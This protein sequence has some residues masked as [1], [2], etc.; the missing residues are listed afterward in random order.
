MLGEPPAN[1]LTSHSPRALGGRRDDWTE[2]M[3]TN[4]EWG[5]GQE[6]GSE[7]PCKHAN[8]GDNAGSQRKIKPR[9]KGVMKVTCGQSN[10]VRA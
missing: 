3:E 8:K 5:A 6:R 9:K 4:R 10:E 7:S 1:V 2:G